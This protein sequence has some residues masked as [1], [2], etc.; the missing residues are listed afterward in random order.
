LVQFGC[1]T[2]RIT[3]RDKLSVS[4]IFVRRFRRD[5]SDGDL[6]ASI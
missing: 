1:L 3:Y 2:D 6:Q 5:G 4:L